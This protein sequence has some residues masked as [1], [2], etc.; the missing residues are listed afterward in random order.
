M[1][2]NYICDYENC[3]KKYITLRGFTRHKKKHEDDG[4]NKT[5]LLL[6]MEISMKEKF[7]D[8]IP[9]DDIKINIKQCVICCDNLSS[10][11]IIDCGHFI[12]CETCSNKM[13]H[14]PIEEQKCPICKKNIEKI[15][16]IYF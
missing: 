15:I 8:Y 9:T 7:M 5:Q 12:L 13:K 10:N 2:T 1:T 16:K 6:A 4:W 14:L 3:N 11:A